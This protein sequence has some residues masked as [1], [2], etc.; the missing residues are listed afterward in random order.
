MSIEPQTP[1]SGNV[2]L[3]AAKPKRRRGRPRSAVKTP[4]KKTV[5]LPAKKRGR[6]IGS[7]KCPTRQPPSSHVVHGKF[8]TYTN[9]APYKTKNGTIVYHKH[10]Y[11]AETQTTRRE[12][13]KNI[14][15]QKTE[16]IK[17]TKEVLSLGNMKN[18]SLEQLNQIQAILR[19]LPCC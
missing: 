2:Q 9:Y 19:P 10:S 15:L 6:P 16:K 12:K 5:L 4:R 13:I 1:S 17:K 11:T 3:P 14:R 18:I 8:T 7:S